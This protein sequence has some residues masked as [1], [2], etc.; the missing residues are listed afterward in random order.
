LRELASE[1]G[2]VLIFDEITSG[3]RMCAGGIHRNYNVHPDMAVFAK[4]MANGYAMSVVLGTEEV[5]EAAQTTFISSTNWTERVGPVASLATIRKYLRL[6][7]EKHLIE[8]GNQV[9]QIW[10]DS[11]KNHGLEINITGLPSLAT[12]G[13]KNSNAMALN[14]RFTI[15]LLK[16]GFLGFRQFKSSFAHQQVDLA[17]YHKAVNEVFTIIAADPTGSELDTP[18]AQTGFQRLTK[19]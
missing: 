18:I 12:F 8:T 9:K 15:E 5:M 19:E 4:S 6:R 10:Q 16:R 13:F 1:I 11:A 7:V 17:K 2:A 14:T 3:F